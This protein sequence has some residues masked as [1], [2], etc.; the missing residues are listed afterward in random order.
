MFM[1]ISDGKDSFLFPLVDRVLT[2]GSTME[3]TGTLPAGFAVMADE[4]RS[5]TVTIK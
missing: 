4:V 1:R 5:L 2:D 3:S